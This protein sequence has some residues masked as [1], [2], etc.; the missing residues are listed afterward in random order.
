MLELQTFVLLL[1]ISFIILLLYNH[2]HTIDKKEGFTQSVP[3]IVKRNDE[4]YDDFYAE[5]YD[6]LYEPIQNVDTITTILIENTEINKE[7]IL[8]IIGSDS[9]EQINHLQ[10]KGYNTFMVDKSSSMIDYAKNKYPMIQ[11][12][13]DNSELPMIYNQAT[14]T[15]ILCIDFHLYKIKNKQSFFRNIYHWI[16][17]NGYFIIQLAD[18]NQFN[19][20]IPAGKSIVLDKPQKYSNERITETEIDFG[21]FYYKSKYNFDKIQQNIVTFS[22]TFI[23]TNNK[24]VRINEQILYMENIETIL[25]L[26]HYCGFIVKTKYNVKNDINQSI[27]ILQRPP[28]SFSR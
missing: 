18:P 14:F 7:S 21:S 3:F 2:Y 10:L 26:L 20:I 1:T 22:E 4:I 28:S 24:N 17:P 19:T 11:A 27:Y 25:Q 15:H 6:T 12:M 8:L 16:I 23:D 9:G 5:I 13:T